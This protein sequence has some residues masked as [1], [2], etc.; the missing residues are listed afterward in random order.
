MGILS[1][2]THQNNRDWAGPVSTMLLF[3]CSGIGALYNKYVKVFRFGTIMY[4]ASLG[5]TVYVGSS[6]VFI[7]IG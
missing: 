2:I 1:Q 4:F 7:L 6:I 3:I 5:Y